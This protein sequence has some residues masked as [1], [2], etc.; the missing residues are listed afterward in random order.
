MS[1]IRIEKRHPCSFGSDNDALRHYGVKFVCTRMGYTS[2]NCQEHACPGQPAC[3]IPVTNPHRF[4]LDFKAVCLHCDHLG[5]ATW[6]VDETDDY[7]CGK[8]VTKTKGK[9]VRIEFRAAELAK[10]LFSEMVEI[11]DK[12]RPVKKKRKMKLKN[13]FGEGCPVRKTVKGSGKGKGGKKRKKCDGFANYLC[14]KRKAYFCYSHAHS[15]DNKGCCTYVHYHEGMNDTTYK[16]EK[17]GSVGTFGTFGTIGNPDVER[18]VTTDWM[19]GDENS[20]EVGNANPCKKCGNESDYWCKKK[21][22][23]RCFTHIHNRW[24]CCDYAAGD[25]GETGGSPSRKVLKEVQFVEAS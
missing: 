14:K 16:K 18:G 5:D 25:S 12:E 20:G 9:M 7:V 2:F 22:Q 24:D 17:G 1:T 13:K 11:P 21:N 10:L 6:Y 3:C 4:V 23:W 8:H 19:E 15:L